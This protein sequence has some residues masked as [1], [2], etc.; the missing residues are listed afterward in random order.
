MLAFYLPVFGPCMFY[1]GFVLR[2]MAF[3][4]GVLGK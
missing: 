4:M 2:S 1:F 3:A